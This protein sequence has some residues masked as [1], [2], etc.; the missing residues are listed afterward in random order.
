MLQLRHDA[1]IVLNVD[2]I[3]RKANVRGRLVLFG[4]K[5]NKLELITEMDAPTLY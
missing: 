4:W 2:W 1:W 5:K 3:W